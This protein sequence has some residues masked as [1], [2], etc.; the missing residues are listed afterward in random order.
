MAY[1]HRFENK[2]IVGP[3]Q[4]SPFVF[5]FADHIQSHCKQRKSKA[6]QMLNQKFLITLMM[7]KSDT[8]SDKFLLF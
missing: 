6:K 8:H 5:Q 1:A 2:I 3:K 4:K 7:M